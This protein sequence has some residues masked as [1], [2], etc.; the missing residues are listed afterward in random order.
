MRNKI[1]IFCLIGLLFL[2]QVLLAQQV[3]Q[4]V[5][6]ANAQTQPGKISLDM[7]GMDI[8]DVL[9]ILAMRG[10]LNI[11]AGKNVR[12]KVTLFL[13]NVEVMDALEIILAANGLAYEQ[14]G[15]IINVMTDRDYELLYGE[16]S[17]DKKVVKVIRL[18]FAK[19]V[20][21]SKTLNQIKSKIGKVVVD[22]GSNTMVLIDL[23]QKIKEMEEAVNNMD[24]PIET[25]TFSLNYAKAS[26]LEGKIKGIL[27]ANVGELQ[28]DERMNKI[29]V[30]DLPEKIDRIARLI[31]DFDE[32]DEIVLIEAKIVEIILN[33]DVSYGINWN[34]VFA[35]ID[36]IAACDLSVSLPSEVGAWPHTFTYT[37]AHGATE[38]GNQVILKLLEQ[39]GKT[40]VLSTPR[41]TV[42]NN[43][44][45][46]VLVGTKE[47]Y[48]TSTITQTNGTT[49][50]ADNVEFVDVG[51]RLSVTPTISRDGN[52]TMKIKPEVSSAGTPLQLT[53]ADGSVRTS[54]PIITT[55][56]AETQLIV[57]DGTTII[58]AGLMKDTRTDNTEKIPGLGDIPL[59]GHFFRSRGKGDVK[60]ELV[61]F[62]TPHIIK[63]V[64]DYSH[65]ALAY[66]YQHENTGINAD[67]TYYNYMMMQ[68]ETEDVEVDSMAKDTDTIPDVFPQY[69]NYLSGRIEQ[70]LQG[71]IPYRV[72]RQEVELS[73]VL[74]RD[75]SLIGRPIILSP[76][77]AE[78]KELIT[79]SVE[80]SVPFFPFPEGY[81]KSE[82]TFILTVCFG[83]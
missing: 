32:K 71:N 69:C 17:F 13:K 2:P 16:M 30:T 53:N 33:K 24:L 3:G 80:D 74:A 51:V 73:F 21:V 44:E 27:T 61:I 9:K 25:R 12:G 5:E 50:T 52:I 35:G 45:A 23:P 64:E 83:N 56:E 8:I 48:V 65:Q 37:R 20:E 6:A 75:G 76:A 42:A 11:V 77:D 47:A 7:K 82:Q 59:L 41:I 28:V 60:T 4:S 15:D 62:L 68:P 10:N 46:K 14:K 22:E 31:T 54:V 72:E 39:L 40:D 79:K 29:V 26:D 19:A 67:P 66:I 43:E 38:Y 36:T 49:T 78:I 58:M 34:N 57:K 70:N 81:E 18:D 1:L 63:E 55:S